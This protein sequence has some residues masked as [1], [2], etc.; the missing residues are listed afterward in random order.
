MYAADNDSN[1]LC[2]TDM[3]FMDSTFRTAPKL[4]MQ[5][6]VI[7]GAVGELSV[8][9]VYAHLERKNTEMFTA[10]ANECDNRNWVLNPNFV[11][12]DFEDAVIK[13]LFAVFG[14]HSEIFC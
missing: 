6:Y 10:L 4:H 1:L 2:D 8:P 9:L 14:L 13:G 7:H 12:I 3:L 5:L 11:Y